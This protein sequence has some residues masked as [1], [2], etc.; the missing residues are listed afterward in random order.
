MLFTAGASWFVAF[1]SAAIRVPSACRKARCLLS[2]KA[3][4]F[5]KMHASCACK[6]VSYPPAEHMK[7]VTPRVLTGIRCIWLAVNVL[8]CYILLTT[9]RVLHHDTRT[10][11]VRPRVP[12]AATTAS[13]H[14]G[15]RRNKGLLCTMVRDEPA[16]VL[17]EW[18]SF[19]ARQGFGTIVVYDDESQAPH[20][21][22][23]TLEQVQGSISFVAPFPDPAALT[24]CSSE[25]DS[26]TCSFLLNCHSWR[27]G[28][29]RGDNGVGA[30]Q[31]AAWDDCITRHSQHAEFFTNIDI[32]EFVYPCHASAA[33]G[34]D[35]WVQ[36]QQLTASWNLE[37]VK[38]GPASW[39]G[40]AEN[41]SLAAGVLAAATLRA[42]Y[43]FLGDDEDTL[44]ER[45][46]PGDHAGP[47]CES[48]GSMKRI[49]LMKYLKPGGVDVHSH[50]LI[51]E[52]IP[53]DW[54]TIATWESTHNAGLCCNHYPIRSLGHLQR[55]AAQNVNS[56][57]LQQKAQARRS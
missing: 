16:E 3:G 8:L 48:S 27:Q 15:E 52:R 51:E 41:A 9:A 5:I 40:G 35:A 6:Q 36:T 49:S 17:R 26:E 30:C 24:S 38:F 12:I 53:S 18:A 34:V 56:F 43:T 45:H 57:I 10:V 25:S 31:L 20:H 46:C 32:D 55:K 11:V 33:W 19:H 22:R 23:T 7:R 21:A 54:T 4:W 28:G 13:H 29:R 39:P 47:L 50:V 42:P 2:I 37:C 44:R 1:L 14:S